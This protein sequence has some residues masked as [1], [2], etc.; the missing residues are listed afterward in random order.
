MGQTP[1]KDAQYAELY[2]SYIQQQQNLI[3]QQQQQINS[4]FN[5]NLQNQMLQQQMPPNMLFQYDMNQFQGQQAPQWQQQQQ[6]TQ[7]QSQSPQTSFTQLQLPSAKTK[8]DP[9]KILGLS[10]EYDEKMLKKAYLKA[11]MKAHPDRGGTPRE[12]QQVSIAFT[13]LQKKLKERENN[14]S[15]EQL[16][17]GAKDFFSQQANTPK[18]NTKMTEKFDID[19]F[20]QIYDKNKI[21]EVYDD[22]YGDWINQNPALESGQ[23]KMFQN[24]FNK[25]M[26][27]ATF[28]NYKREQA[29]NNPQNQLVKYQEPEV[30]ISMSNADSIMTLGQG[31]IANFSGQSDNLTYTDYK[32]AFTDGSML[33]DPSTVDTSGR[34]N[35]VRGI[36]SQRSNISYQMTQEDQIRLAQQQAFASNAERDRISRLNVY[37]RQHGEAYEKIHSMLLR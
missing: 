26:F 22:G 4:L 14:H 32:Q 18:I 8:L 16:R 27:N 33:I 20:N 35:S 17:D 15:H 19:V 9:Y 36:K 5:S 12:F 21:P 28:E 37:D 3:Y 13:L 2:S 31:K 11:A 24:G 1:S 25:D 23:T 6:P 30:K 7:W 29:K 10:K 34:A